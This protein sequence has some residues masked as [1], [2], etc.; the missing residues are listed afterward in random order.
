MAYP[1]S[2]VETLI[3]FAISKACSELTH[4]WVVGVAHQRER[5]PY[6][7]VIKAKSNF[8]ILRILRKSN[9]GV[10]VRKPGLASQIISDKLNNPNQ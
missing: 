3:K 9:Q 8:E 10:A 4:E 1:R 5:A 6:D 2:D 7:S